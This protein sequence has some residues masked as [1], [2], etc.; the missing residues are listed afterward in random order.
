[1]CKNNLKKVVVLGTGGTIA[2][3]ATSSAD[4]TGYTAAQIS[5]AQLLQ[6]VP[7]LEQALGGHALHSEQV[8]QLDSK[9]MDFATM[10]RLAARCLHW[11]A[12]D[13][14]AGIV[15]TH[16]TDTL[17][18]TAY[19]LHLLLPAFKPV[20]LTC[21]M[22]P[23]TS[24]QADG[25]TNLRDAVAL[26]L[27]PQA[28]GVLCV[29]AGDVHQGALVQKVH[30]HR[31]NAFSSGDAEPAGRMATKAHN[32]GE[33]AC[34]TWKASTTPL[35]HEKLPNASVD[36]AREAIKY[37]ANITRWPRVEIILN[38]TSASGALVRALLQEQGDNRV[39][40]IIAAGTGNG[41][42]HH[43]LQTALLQA[44]AQGIQ[45]MRSTRCQGGVTDTPNDALPG[46]GSLPYSKARIRMVLQ[47]AGVALTG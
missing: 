28:R 4:H 1:M 41:T 3:T 2:G 14:V 27:D 32:V 5:V 10:A 18:E 36:T 20:V 21:A 6:V 34:V 45:V 17:E 44:Q 26:A 11:M 47:L 19:F 43:D 33:M 35:Y 16:G 13:D 29:C 22:R 39:Q 37:I 38:H 31:L 25:P 46:A 24:S 23:A 12:Q 9:D 42:L 30:A 15:I 7:G 40:G 8:A